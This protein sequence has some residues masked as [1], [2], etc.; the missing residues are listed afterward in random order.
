MPN[1]EHGCDGRGADKPGL[2]QIFND[3]IWKGHEDGWALTAAISGAHTVGRAKSENSGY[4]GFWSDTKN[5][6]IFNNNYYWSVIFKGW[7]PLLKV[8]GNPNINQWKRI[9]LGRFLKN[10]ELMLTTD[11][12][13][14]YRNNKKYITC[15]HSPERSDD[16][17][18]GWLQNRYE[19]GVNFFD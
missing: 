19:C 18:A 12:C 8:N 4:Q 5:S 1:P 7:G 3:N 17:K 10:E 15:E 16:W 6:G 2:E 14:A 11:L 13:L 9:D